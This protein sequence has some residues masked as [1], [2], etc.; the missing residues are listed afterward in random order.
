MLTFLHHL[1]HRSILKLLR[2]ATGTWIR[3]LGRLVIKRCCLDQWISSKNKIHLTGSVPYLHCGVAS[4]SNCILPDL[5]VLNLFQYS[6]ISIE[7]Q[8]CIKFQDHYLTLRQMVCPPN[9]LSLLLHG[10][11]PRN[12]CGDMAILLY[13]II[14]ISYFLIFSTSQC[15]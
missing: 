12:K 2:H 11:R 6:G 8:G 5:P 14:P 9:Y 13:I 1:D 7:L 10:W 3:A 15:F 4:P